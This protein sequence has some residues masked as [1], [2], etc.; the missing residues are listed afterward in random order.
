MGQA[1]IKTDTHFSTSLLIGT[2][3]ANR[4]VTPQQ[5]G[6]G[7]VYSRGCVKDRMKTRFRLIRRGLRGGT[8]YCVDTTTGKRTSLRTGSEDE[9][10]QLVEARNQAQR[11]PEINLQIAKAYM[12]AADESFVNRTWQEVMDEILKL[13]QNATQRRWQTAIKEKAFDS[14][15]HLAVLE[16]RPEYFLRVLET[17]KV[18][19]NVYQRRI[20]NFALDMTWLPWPVRPNG[21]SRSI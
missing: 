5:C 10:H 1:D 3:G 21:K 17:G 19:T 7:L 12:A 15:R 13:K 8:Y 20:H 11:Q 6:V 16:T 2:T 9:A 18:S 14:L 4:P